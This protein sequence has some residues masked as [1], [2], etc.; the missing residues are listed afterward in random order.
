M[1]F[2][3]NNKENYF[4]DFLR[5]I[6]SLCILF[7]HSWIFSGTFGNGI[8]NNGYLAVDFYF[9]VTGYLMINSIYNHKNNNL[10]VLKDSF[11]FVHRKIKKLLPALVATFLVGVLFV[12]GKSILSDPK[13][14]LSNQLW[15]ELF[16]L[17]I[18]GYP[19]SVNS[20]WWYISAMIFVIALLYPFATKYKENYCKYICPLVIIFTLGL[21][22]VCKININDPLTIS[23]FLRNGF[24][25]ALIF[26]PLGNISY[27]ITDILKRKNFSKYKI[28]LLSLIEIILYV[29]IVLNMQYLFIG[30]FL[31]AILLALNISLTFSNVTLAPKIFK[32]TIWKKLGN[33]GFYIFLCNI[34]IRT[35]MLRKYADLGLTYKQLLFRFLIITCI[36]SLILYIIVEIVYKKLILKRIMN[37]KNKKS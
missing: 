37:I 29:A 15:P 11:N 24:Y 2:M 13:I 34:S 6:F 16:Q 12:Y 20:S 23:F 35:Y 31:C 9:I 17:G 21:V 3:S 26:I 1:L 14:L 8:L 30:T 28:I 7:Y 25:K 18:L 4:I 10:S 36:T 27:I 5:F 33:Y 19:L 32:H 22:N